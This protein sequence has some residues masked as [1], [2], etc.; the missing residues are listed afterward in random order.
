MLLLPLLWPPL[1]N[2]HQAKDTALLLGHSRMALHGSTCAAAIP[3][4]SFCTSC[5]AWGCPG[6]QKWHFHGYSR[7]TSTPLP[8]ILVFV[9]TSIP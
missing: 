2:L 5:A 9:A 4:R 3:W 1:G 6:G 7:G 8:E